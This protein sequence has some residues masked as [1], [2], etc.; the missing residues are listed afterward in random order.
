MKT[1]SLHLLTDGP[2]TPGRF[3]GLSVVLCGPL[4][5]VIPGQRR[6]DR[7]DCSTKMTGWQS[8]Y[9]LGGKLIFYLQYYKDRSTDDRVHILYFSA[10]LS[11]VQWMTVNMSRS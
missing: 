8:G 6:D 9:K 1:I 7:W 5:A 4:P 11:R 3:D 10:E 2:E